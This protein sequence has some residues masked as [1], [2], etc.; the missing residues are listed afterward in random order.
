MKFQPVVVVHGGAGNL[1]RSFVEEKKEQIQEAVLSALRAAYACLAK[2]GTAEEAVLE[3]ILCLENHEV[4][5]AGKGAVLNEK[6]E[7]ELDAAIM[8][9][10]NLS[11]GAVVG[12]NDIKNPIKAAYAVKEKT[13]HV[14]LKGDCLLDANLF[15]DLE[16]VNPSYFIIPHRQKQLVDAK[17]ANAVTMDHDDDSKK[18]GTVGC[19]VFDGN[20]NL[21]AGTSTGGMTNKMVG[22]IGDSPLI[23]SGTYAENGVC[24]ISCT[25]QGE[26]FIKKVAAFDVAARMKYAKVNLFDASSAVIKGISEINGSGGLIAVDSHGTISTPY[27]TSAMIRGWKDSGPYK[28]AVFE[29]NI[30]EGT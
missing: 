9:G 17:K 21:A 4:L 30:Y 8:N 6:G 23:G 2:K 18:H 16:R 19:V 28:V 14:L 10:A 27:N 29:E 22:R 15:G 7:I 1:S 24:A 13:S 3:A 5:N 20:G 12:V 26:Y 11:C 25:G